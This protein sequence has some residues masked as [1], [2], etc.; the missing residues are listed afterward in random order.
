MQIEQYTP[1]GKTYVLGEDLSRDGAYSPLVVEVENR[2]RGKQYR[3][4]SIPYRGY[5]SRRYQARFWNYKGYV[6]YWFQ[7]LC[8]SAWD[9]M[10][11]IAI[12]AIVSPIVVAHLP[13]LLREIFQP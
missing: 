10:K 13:A 2:S 5:S 4:Y 11:L 9:R 6:P 1:R 7:D 8:E 3:R 12:T